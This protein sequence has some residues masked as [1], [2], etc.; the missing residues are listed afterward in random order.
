MKFQPYKNGNKIQWSNERYSIILWPV[1]CYQR[2]LLRIY[3]FGAGVEA[4]VDTWNA[5]PFFIPDFLT[6][7]RTI[8]LIIANEIMS[9]LKSVPEDAAGIEVEKVLIQVA[10]RYGG[11]NKKSECCH[12]DES[13]VEVGVRS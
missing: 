8:A 13:L 11:V 1:G 10:G 5:T 7:D 12:I 4:Y 2:F 6:K 3:S 9:R